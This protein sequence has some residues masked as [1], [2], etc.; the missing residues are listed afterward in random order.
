MRFGLKEKERSVTSCVM[1]LRGVGAIN[2]QRRTLNTLQAKEE[3]IYLR[4]I[5]M[6]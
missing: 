6:H 1:Q 2:M 5:F 4:Q 3:S